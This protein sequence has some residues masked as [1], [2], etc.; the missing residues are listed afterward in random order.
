M[1]ANMREPGAMDGSGLG[2]ME[3]SRNR[4]PS[5]TIPKFEGDQRLFNEATHEMERCS[6][7]AQMPPSD[8]GQNFEFCGL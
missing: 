8:E 6:E 3:E 4:A 2:D 1:F 7:V 5:E